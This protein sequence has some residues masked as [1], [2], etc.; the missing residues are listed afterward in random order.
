MSLNDTTIIDKAN[1]QVLLVPGLRQSIAIARGS[2]AVFEYVTGATVQATLYDREGVAVPGIIDL[3]CTD[4]AENPGDYTGLIGSDF[5][6]PVGTGYKL[7]VD[8][9]K[10]ALQAHFKKSVTV[11]ERTD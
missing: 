7:I 5:D 10:G 3:A 2:P 9:A 6:P 8:V 4:L 11:M 1:H